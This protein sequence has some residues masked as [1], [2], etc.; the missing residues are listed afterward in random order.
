MNKTTPQA[1][2]RQIPEPITAWIGQASGKEGI[3][4]RV[5]PHDPP[6]TSVAE[7][8]PLRIVDGKKTA[9]I[10]NAP[11]IEKLR[12]ILQRMRILPDLQVTYWQERNGGIAG[13]EIYFHVEF[14]AA[15]IPTAEPGK[16]FAGRLLMAFSMPS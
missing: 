7:I 1:P 11:L 15:Q 3:E 2:S 5:L 8:K 6:A 14:I 10:E 12:D 4:I 9:F 16:Y 13:N